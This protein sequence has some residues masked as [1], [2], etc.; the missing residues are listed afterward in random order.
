VKSLTLR[1]LFQFS[2]TVVDEFLVKEVG[3]QVKMRRDLRCGLSCP[4]CGGKLLRHRESQLTVFDLPVVDQLAVWVT[5]PVLQGRCTQCQTMSTVRPAEIHPTR[6]ATWRLM[7]TV[8]AWAST[9]PARKVAAMFEISESTVRRYEQ[10]ILE[11]ELPEPDFNGLEVLMVDEKAVRK[12]HGYVTVVLNGLTG[13]LLHMAEGK[14]KESL[15]RFFAKLTSAQK[16]SIHSVCLDRAGAYRKVAQEQVPQAQIIFDRFHIMANLNAALDEV[17]RSEWRNAKQEG[18]RAIKGSRF[19]IAASAERL[20]E[21]GRERLEELQSLNENLSTA[22]VLK[23]EFRLIYKDTF[24]ETTA[25]R[26]MRRWCRTT[27]AAGIKPLER[28]AKGIERDFDEVLAFFKQRL[29]SGKIEA[30]NNQIARLIHRACGMT[31]LRHLFLKMRA[32]SIQQI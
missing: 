19:L 7:R 13:E 4:H 10:D 1:S 3:V 15:A 2:G 31:N 21:S 11:A 23:E 12:K 30:F 26:R 16:E 24:T 27:K 32:Q 28:F 18:K 5:L 8:A 22:Y 20:D 17:R 29:T 6:N 14:K 25:R 9:C